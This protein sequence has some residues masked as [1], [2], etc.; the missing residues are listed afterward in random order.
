[1]ER[2]AAETRELTLVVLASGLASRFGGP[3][4]LTPVGPAGEHLPDYGLFDAYAAG[5]SRA[6]FVVRPEHEQQFREHHKKLRSPRPAMTYVRQDDYWP[7][8]TPRSNRTKPWGTAHAVLA[9]A[10]HAGGHYAVM[11]AD[12]YYGAGAFQQ[13]AGHLRAVPRRTAHF[14]LLGYRLEHTL[15]ATGGVSRAVCGTDD[16][17]YLQH[18]EEVL[19]VQ[20]RQDGIVGYSAATGRSCRLHEDD[21]VC[22][23][24]WGFTGALSPLLE[25]GFTRF[26]AHRGDDEQAEFMIG[27]AVQDMLAGKTAR[28]DVLTS[29]DRCCGLTHPAD[30][31]KVAAR[32]RD[33]VLDKRYPSPL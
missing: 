27:P 14:S 20:R 22:M 24:L 1:M 31:E 15:A 19:N 4:A 3:K 10:V 2:P 25:A 11:N 18:L 33:L 8:N 7:P 29:H 28:V 26:L 23:N 13:I 30:L 5:F 21:V 32:M 6:V 17:G 16:N 9:S 12:D